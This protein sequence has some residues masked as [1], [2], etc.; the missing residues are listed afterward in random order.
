MP[1]TTLDAARLVRPVPGGALEAFVSLP[2]GADAACPGVVVAPPHP[3]LGGDADNNVVLAVARGVLARGWGVLRFNYRGVGGSQADGPALPRY[4]RFAAVERTG[5][6][7]AL[8]ADARAALGLARRLFR[9]VALVGYSFGLAAALPLA[10]EDPA[11]A[12]VGLCPPVGKQALP[13]LEGRPALLLCA[14]DDACAP[15]PPEDALRAAFP[16]AHARV[17]PRLDHF[18]LGQEDRLVRPTLAYLEAHLASLT[19]EETP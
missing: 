2:P 9:A 6:V 4:E 10:L 3:L 18:A 1:A 14:G 12:L 13:G 5:D 15:P 11:L 19:R 8:V 17:L 16:R 7:S